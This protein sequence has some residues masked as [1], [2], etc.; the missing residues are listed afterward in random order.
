[1]VG[2]SRLLSRCFVHAPTWYSVICILVNFGIPVSNPIDMV[3]LLDS[4]Y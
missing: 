2:Y 1:M 4:I 3:N